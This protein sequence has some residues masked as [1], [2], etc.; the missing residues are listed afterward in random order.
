MTCLRGYAVLLTLPV[1][2]SCTSPPTPSARVV[3][4][5]VYTANVDRRVVHPEAIVG[6]RAYVSAVRPLQD[7]RVVSAQLGTR[8][9]LQYEIVGPPRGTVVTLQAKNIFPAV[10][11]TN[12]VTGRH[13]TFDERDVQCIVGT[14]CL[15]G[16]G[17]SEPW[18]LVPGV[19]TFQIL[20]NGRLLLS[21][22]IE[23]V[24]P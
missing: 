21:H 20:L 7:T 2:A 13:A 6:T 11:L 19:W 15:H 12:P 23:V 4:S 9:G 18:E 3:W 1:F 24:I 8:F 17:F 5:G 14:K 16:R 10:G 22:D